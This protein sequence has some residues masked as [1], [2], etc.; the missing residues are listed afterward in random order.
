M[1]IKKKPWDFDFPAL[2][3]FSLLST[4]YSPQAYVLPQ[5]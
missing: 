1:R 3:E 5:I 4:A 2:I